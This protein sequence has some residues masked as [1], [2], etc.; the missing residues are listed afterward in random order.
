MNR[1]CWS[2]IPG[3][4]L[5]ALGC[6]GPTDV[7][8]PALS[9]QIETLPDAVFTVSYDVQLEATG[10]DP[11]R[12]YRWELVAGSGALPSGLTLTSE[13][14]VMGVATAEGTFDFEVEV[15]SGD[16]QAARRQLTINVRR[17][18]GP[19]ESCS[20]Y[21]GSVAAT[22]ADPSLEWNVRFWTDVWEPE[23]L[24]CDLLSQVTRLQGSLAGIESLLGI[25]N[26]PNLT[27]LKL[28]VNSISDLSPLE[29]LAHLTELDLFYNSISDLSPLAGLSE[30]E[31]LGVSS[32]EINDIGPLASLT[33]L[34]TLDLLSND[35]ADL[36]P[37]SGLTDLH[38]LVLNGNRVSDLSALSGL[39]QLT[40]LEFRDGWITRVLDYW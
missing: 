25:Q 17:A 23:D 1:R 13:G 22:F 35:V 12:T 15:S 16:G 39:T 11:S 37:L 38:S 36:G 2:P 24:T 9:V 32:N 6:D 26:L 10:G 3:L 28:D 34:T 7:T 18:I 14:Q 31:W 20:D 8:F 21:P 40:T 27:W 5:L 33:R 30:L 19:E 29:S 4:I